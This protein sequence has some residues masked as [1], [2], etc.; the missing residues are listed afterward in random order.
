MVIAPRVTR[1]LAQLTIC[2]SAG[3]RQVHR[4]PGTCPGSSGGPVRLCPA[5][6]NELST[7]ESTLASSVGLTPTEL[8][9]ERQATTALRTL[10]KSA[11][12][13]DYSALKLPLPARSRCLLRC[14]RPATSRPNLNRAAETGCRS[15]FHLVHLPC[16]QL[17]QV[18]A[19]SSQA[20]RV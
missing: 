20:V 11:A 12:R 1:Q 10:T 8:R 17:S 6:L 4:H 2:G 18:R 19:A 13:A 15:A 16:K 5:P 7:A 3:S 9:T 14:P